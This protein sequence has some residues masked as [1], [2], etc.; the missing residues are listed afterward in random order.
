MDLSG[1]NTLYGSAGD[2]V[3]NGG[4]GED[5]LKGEAGND[6]YIWGENYG[7]DVINNWE[8]DNS[9]SDKVSIQNGSLD[10]YTL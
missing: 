9:S 2:D 4:A 3:M 5:Y 6:T 10:D 7:N 1:N 8:A